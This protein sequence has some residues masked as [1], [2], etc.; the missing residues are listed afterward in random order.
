MQKIKLG[1]L[2]LTLSLITVV[3][4]GFSGHVFAT[5]QL[6]DDAC[7][8]L[9]QLDGSSDCGGGD[10][11]VNKLVSSIINILSILIGVVAVIMIIVGGLKYVTASGD[12]ANITSAKN[13]LLYALIGLFIASIAQFLV[14]YV[15]STG[16]AVVK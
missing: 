4:L 5:G 6:K 8:G 11:G 12:P 13:T 7:A 15:L 14:H 10:T 9:Q 3:G 2:T 1:I 16:H